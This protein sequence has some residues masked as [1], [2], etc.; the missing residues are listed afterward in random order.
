MSAIRLTGELPYSVSG[1]SQLLGG[2]NSLFKRIL[3][4]ALCQRSPNFLAPGTGFVEDSFSTEGRGRLRRKRENGERWG[5][6]DEALLARPPLTSCCAAQLLTG[7]G[8]VV[9]CGPG[10]G[11]PCVML[12]FADRTWRER[13]VSPTSRPGPVETRC[14]GVSAGIKAC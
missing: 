2:T 12:S 1:W 11:D 10:V 4:D 9:V 3:L 6:A 8:P 14:R 5:A 7:C 13:A